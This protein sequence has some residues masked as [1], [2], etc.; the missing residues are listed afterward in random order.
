MFVNQ[1]EGYWRWPTHILLQ[2]SFPRSFL[3]SADWRGAFPPTCGWIVTSDA[4]GFLCS[5]GSPAIPVVSHLKPPPDCTACSCR[6]LLPVPK[7][8]L[9]PKMPIK[10]SR[11][12][13]ISYKL[14]LF[15]PCFP[16]SNTHFDPPDIHPGLWRWNAMPCCSWHSWWKCCRAAVS[17]ETQ[18]GPNCWVFGSSVGVPNPH[19]SP[20]CAKKSTRCARGAFCWE[21]KLEPNWRFEA[22]RWH[23][24]KT[25]KPWPF[26]KLKWRCSPCHLEAYD[27]PRL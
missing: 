9:L 19:E 16:H 1:I 17:S 6:L 12:T 4:E 11:E 26:G 3:P 7:M 5:K 25:C 21:R 23:P 22:P 18:F 2:L 27:S 8:Q 13:F 24:W 14:H 20:R 10:L 15:W